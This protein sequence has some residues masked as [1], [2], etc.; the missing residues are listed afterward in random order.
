LFTTAALA[1]AVAVM[2]IMLWRRYI[3]RQQTAA[4][5]LPGVAIGL[6]SGALLGTGVGVIV[7]IGTV[8]L[9]RAL[10]R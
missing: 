10:G 1:P 4:S 9:A 2:G 6:A 5:L 3:N 8:A 7:L